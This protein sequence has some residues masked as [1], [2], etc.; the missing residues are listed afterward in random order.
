MEKEMSL[1]VYNEIKLKSISELLGKNFFIP[2][3]QRG[4]R[5]D[6][7]QV[8]DLL[9]DIY[10]FTKK[11]NK[12][13]KEF[14]CLQP[15]VVRKCSDEEKV[16]NNLQSELDNNEWY[17][18][19]DGQ[20][21]LTTI[22]IILTY[23]VE[24]HLKG[25]ELKDEYKKSEFLLKYETRPDTKSYLEKIEEKKSNDTIDFHYIYQAYTSISAWF[26]QYDR[27]VRE[28]ILN[29]LVLE[30]DK[31]PD[32]GVVQVIWYE[33]NDKDNKPIDTFIRINMGKIPLTNAEL[34]KALF[35]QKRNFGTD[36]I[37]ELRQIEI[38]NEWDRMEYTLQSED[39]WW[40]LNKEQNNTPA[41]IEF[42]FEII[43]KLARQE[44][45]KFFDSEFGTD[46]YKIFRYFNSLISVDENIFNTIKKE[47]NKIKYYFFA[48]EEWFNKPVWYHYIGFLIYCDVNIIDIYKIY[49]NKKKD[50][51]TN[52]LIKE[53]KEQFKKVE[54]EKDDAK[55]S[56]NLSFN[57]PQK[58]K[59]RPLLLLFNIEFIVKHY[60]E[61]ISKNSSEEDFFIL[62]FP[63]KMFKNE[64]WDIE[65]I[66]SYTPN[67]I[68]KFE[69]Q[70]D[71]LDVNKDDLKDDIDEATIKEIEKF[72]KA[73]ESS[74]FEELYKKLSLIFSEKELDEETKNG[75]GNLTLLN[76]EINRGYGNSL[77]P[78]KRRIIIEND[79]QGKFIPICTKHVFLKYFDQK[80]TS[81][82]KWSR[83]D[84]D[85]YQNHIGSILEKFLTFKKRNKDE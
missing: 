46:E 36:D 79:M 77:F 68:K 56:I 41:R 50:E 62:K 40:F 8:K 27:S 38:A 20:Q 76:A 2:S 33:I 22:R 14:Y 35:L 80:G 84:I 12:S 13:D 3:Y 11:K 10:S 67:S 72:L 74:N 6:K 59:I 15:I 82:T 81:R 28:S 7:Q 29:T 21:R 1:S 85:G 44:D 39:F 45:E 78:T 16:K 25:A 17:E 65:H 60:E 23:L 73:N 53:I 57:H 54:C 32:D 5:W 66:D 83:E 71:W 43:Y 18:I 9:D 42:L 34:I 75:I 26:N 55:F 37:A 4:Y 69:D 70:K 24:H 48:F 58:E 63:F 52:A 64:N 30:K 49:Q 47:W 19:I 31:K 51:F 61:I